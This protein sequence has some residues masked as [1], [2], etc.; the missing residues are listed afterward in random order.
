MIRRLVDWVCF[1]VVAAVCVAVGVV[2]MAWGIEGLVS[3]GAFP[4]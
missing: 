4:S 3:L 2:A 1:T